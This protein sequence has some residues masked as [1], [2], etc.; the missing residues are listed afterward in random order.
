MKSL[1]VNILLMA[2]AFSGT[3]LYVKYNGKSNNYNTVQEA[4]NKAAEINPK[5]E[6]ERVTIHI[7]PSTNHCQNSLYYFYK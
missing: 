3:D 2:Y 5:S 1:I 4:V 7:A 6:S